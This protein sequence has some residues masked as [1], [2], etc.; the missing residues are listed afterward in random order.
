MCAPVAT[1]PTLV[2]GRLRAAD[3]A[4]RTDGATGAS[5]GALASPPRAGAA[6]L[7]PDAAASVVQFGGGRAPP[8][9]PRPRRQ[10][11]SRSPR[12]LTRSRFL[13][14]ARWAGTRR[15]STH[16]S[17][18]HARGDVATPPARGHASSIASEAGVLPLL[19]GESPRHGGEGHRG[20]GGHDDRATRDAAPTGRRGRF[21][22]QRGQGARANGRW[23]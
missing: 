9:T 5:T 15:R 17:P 18:M 16:G 7:G 22:R 4:C 11:R 21:P 12:V 13:P 2:Q 23:T 14:P 10:R 19:A 8:V 3:G 1:V 6:L 20:E